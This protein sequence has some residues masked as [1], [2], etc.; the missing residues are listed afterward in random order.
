MIQFLSS[1]CVCNTWTDVKLLFRCRGC[2]G[3]T[4]DWH[5]QRRQCVICDIDGDAHR[6]T[7]CS[8]YCNGTGL[9]QVPL[10]DIFRSTLHQKSDLIARCGFSSR[11]I[12]FH[13]GSGMVPWTH[14]REPICENEDERNSEFTHFNLVIRLRKVKQSALPF[15]TIFV[16]SR[17]SCRFCDAP[18]NVRSCRLCDA[19]DNVKS[20]QAKLLRTATNLPLA[21][22]SALCSMT[23]WHLRLQACPLP[24]SM[25]HF[26]FWWGWTYCAPHSWE[27][28]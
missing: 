19:P 8:F 6:H 10:S 3:C 14:L 25:V 18:D 22:K 7:C 5:Q 1:V 4:L 26:G 15:L 17:R 20:A 2:Q 13:G 24:A 11:R 28:E 12:T 9:S 23:S 27:I 21:I 16:T